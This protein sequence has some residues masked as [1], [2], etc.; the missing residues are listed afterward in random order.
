MSEEYDADVTGLRPP[1]G[2]GANQSALAVSIG[3]LIDGRYELIARLGEGGMGEVF[4]AVDRL[5]Q[6]Q[7]ARDPYVA[8]KIL[9]PGLQQDPTAVKALHREFTRARG[10]S[11]VNILR[12]DLFGQDRKSGLHFIV[13][14][15]LE[16]RSLESLMNESRNR[17]G[18]SWAEVSPLL[19]QICAGLQCAHEEGIIHSDIKPSN[20]FIT[21]RAKIKILDFGIAALRPGASD[22]D[23]VTRYDPRKLGALSPAYASLEMFEGRPAH[24]SDDVYSLA[25]VTYEWL[26]GRHPYQ[27]AGPA[28]TG[29]PA[30]EATGEPPRIPG[31]TRSQNE[32]LRLALALRRENRTQTI[33]EFWHSMAAGERPA[34]DADQSV[35]LVA[36]AQRIGRLLQ[37]IKWRGQVLPSMVLL[38]FLVLLLTM[39]L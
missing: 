7:E 17:S 4:K 27:R 29:I 15:L 38:T 11:H 23:R 12:I 28:A 1:S 37:E 22:D 20:L 34:G 30:R 32:A 14:E 18:Q 3:S 26:S 33:R 24:D 35:A 21:D 6:A 5:A 31:V 8:I 2:G 25:C 16:G 10:L 13:M 9:K 36:G 19:V 39:I